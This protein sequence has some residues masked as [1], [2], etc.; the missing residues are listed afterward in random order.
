MTTSDRIV[1]PGATTV[2]PVPEGE[3]TI[4]PWGGVKKSRRRVC[5]GNTKDGDRIARTAFA[6]AATLLS[7][8]CAPALDWRLM[9]LAGT[10]LQVSFPCRPSA[11]ARNLT[12][13]NTPLHWTLTACDAGDMTFAVAWA[14]VPDPARTTAVLQALA[15]QTGENLRAAPQ[16]VQAASVPGM[17]PHLASQWMRFLGRSPDGK[18]LAQQVLLFTHGLRVYQASVLGAGAEPAGQAAAPTFFG[19]LRVLA[20]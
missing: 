12:V 2:H 9:T 10:P 6:L 8:A 13:G 17:T 18:V 15:R 20:P 16:A 11:M 4:S 5:R 1:C 14:D 3:T 19:A 7:V